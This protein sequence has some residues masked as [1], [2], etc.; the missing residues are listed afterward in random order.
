LSLTVEL[1]VGPT[2]AVLAEVAPASSSVLKGHPSHHVRLPEAAMCCAKPP[3]TTPPSSVLLTPP[4]LRR[5]RFLMALWHSRIRIRI[6]AL[7]TPIRLVLRMR[8]RA[9]GTKASAFA[10]TTGT[11][12]VGIGRWGAVKIRRPGFCFTVGSRTLHRSCAP[13]K[14]TCLPPSW[15]I[16]CRQ[17]GPI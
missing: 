10:T 9:S 7:S 3:Q 12:A 17:R 2:C 8:D 15:P 1:P 4:A 16:A 5:V 14:H 13:G 11:L 6:A